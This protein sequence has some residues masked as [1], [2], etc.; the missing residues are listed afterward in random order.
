MLLLFSLPVA[1]ADVYQAALEAAT[2]GTPNAVVAQAF[3]EA[4]G[5]GT[6]N[7]AVAQAFVE[8]IAPR[9]GRRRGA[10]EEWLFT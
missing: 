9:A 6:P 10:D 5:A 4:A 1:H 8:F 2:A 7:A 3:V